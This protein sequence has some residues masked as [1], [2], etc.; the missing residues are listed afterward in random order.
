MQKTEADIESQVLELSTEALGAFCEDISG[1]FGVEMNSS[2]QAGVKETVSGLQ[3]RFKKLTAVNSVSSE[4]V[5]NGT[6]YV[7]FDQG[8]LFTLSGVVVMLPENRI[9]EVILQG[10]REEAQ[11]MSDAIAELG[12]MMVGTWD[13]VF[14]ES[15]RKRH[16]HFKQTGTFIGKPWDDPQKILGVGSDEE[17][18]FISATMKVESYPEFTCGVIFPPN[19]FASEG[20]IGSKAEEVLPGGQE[21]ADSSESAIDDANVE[22]EGADVETEAVQDESAEAV[23]E[24]ADAAA[25]DEAEVSEVGESASVVGEL[26]EGEGIVEAAEDVVEREDTAAAAEEITVGGQGAGSAQVTAESQSCDTAL[27]LTA[28][29]IMQREPAWLGPEDTVQDAINTM[30]RHETG[31]VMIGSGGVLEGIVSRSDAAGAVSPYLRPVFAKWKRPQDDATLQIKLS[32]IM[33]RPVRTITPQ[34]PLDVIIDTMLHFGG[35]CLP[36][37]D[38]GGTVEGIVTVFDIFR[39]LTTSRDVSQTGRMPQA[40]LPV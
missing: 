16:R 26:Q 30:Q 27:T 7:V 32:W 11:R 22:G 40:A 21:E 29:Q 14:R 8:G 12:N 35:R 20:S 13:R 4:G 6:F 31:Y 37:V 36:V 10:S 39:V 25:G 23:G 38:Q 17:F 3:K 19:V 5:L 15:L 28:G 33:T 1:M 24:V 34:T 18:L 2:V 9:K